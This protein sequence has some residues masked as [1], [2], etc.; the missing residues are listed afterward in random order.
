M[1]RDIV[2]IADNIRSSHNVGSL[3]RS[4]EGL[5]VSKVYLTGYTPYPNKQNDTRLPHIANKINNRIIKTSL[6]AESTI[7]WDFKEN[8]PDLINGLKI[9]DYEI[10][11][12]ELTKDAVELQNLKIP[13]R[14]AFIF[15]NER[16]GIEKLHL[17]LTDKTVFV[18][19]LGSKESFNVVQVA[20]M[21]LYTAR[22]N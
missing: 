3:L 10:V 13:K 17:K 16:T 22:Y 1:D 21:V 14:I 2:V 5:G 11:A 12:V 19:M 6:G 4:C 20:A 8:Y 18:P 9:Q 7:N 15:G